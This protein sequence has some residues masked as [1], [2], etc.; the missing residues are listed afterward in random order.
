MQTL[1]EKYHELL[2]SDY[3]QLGE[4]MKKIFNQHSLRIQIDTRKRPKSMEIPKDEDKRHT[5][6]D[7]ASLFQ[8]INPLKKGIS[9]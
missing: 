1:I 7:T 6:L 9:S 8:M 2:L 4:D 3:D 5:R